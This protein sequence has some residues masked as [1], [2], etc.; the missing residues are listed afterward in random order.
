M[1]LRTG[2]RGRNGSHFMNDKARVREE[3]IIEKHLAISRDGYGALARVIKFCCAGC[4]LCISVCP[5]QSLSFDEE[6]KRPYLRGRCDGCGWCYLACPRSFLPLSRIRDTYYGRGKG[7]EQQR[8]GEFQDI[9]VAR[10]LTDAIYREGTPGGTTTA[11]VHFLLERGYADAA[12]LTRGTHPDHTYCMHPE[13]YIARSPEEVLFSSHSKFEISPVLSKL[14]ELSQQERGI[15]VG[16]PCHIM[17][18]RKLQIVAAD[19]VFHQKMGELSRCAHSLTAK[20]KFALSINCFLNHTSMDKAYRWLGVNERDI[21]RF[22]ENVSKELFEKALREGKDWRWLIKS[23]VVTKDGLEHHYDLLALGA[24]V[25]YSG[26]LLCDDSIVSSHADA[27]IGFFGAE[28][29]ERE[30]GWNSLVIMNGELKTIIDEMVSMKKLERKPM[31]KGYG[32]VIRKVVEWCMRTLMPP[33]DVMGVARYLRTGAW[34][35]PKVLK[36]MR[37]PR[38]GTYILGL[39]LLFLAQTLRRKI[40]FEGALRALKKAGAY[41]TTVY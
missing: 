9:C 3:R 20:V 22:N 19:D 34:T 41:Y 7:E 18:F 29:G 14:R 15:F 31:L 8:L 2:G 27:S 6:R 21:V 35:Y 17:A 36:R 11:I 5:H 24:L 16:T 25:L 37:G 13:P 40:F 30:F 26:C 10:S 38:R 12:L 1:L 4:G 39:E 32:R 33:L 28:T 23:C